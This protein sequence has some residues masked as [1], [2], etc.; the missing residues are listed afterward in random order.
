MCEKFILIGSSHG[1]LLIY[2][3]ALKNCL[4]FWGCLTWTSQKN[5]VC[6]EEIIF[7]DLKTPIWVKKKKICVGFLAV[8]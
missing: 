3:S 4:P 5:F 7:S 1:L 2:L 6:A 8:K